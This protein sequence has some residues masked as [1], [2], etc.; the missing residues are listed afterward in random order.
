MSSAHEKW[1]QK[2]KCC[3]DISVHN[4]VRS[5]MVEDGEVEEKNCWIKWCRM[6]YFND[7]F[8][9]FLGQL[10]CCQ[11]RVRKLSD[12]IKNILICFLKMNEGLMGLNDMRV[13]N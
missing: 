8:T 3:V 6:N 5:I 11:W 9:M 1:G 12:F 2:Q 7:V 4:K 10:H 13:S